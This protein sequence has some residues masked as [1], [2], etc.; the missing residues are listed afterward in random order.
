MNVVIEGK[1]LE[2]LLDDLRREHR[3]LDTQIS[4]MQTGIAFDPLLIRRLKRRKLQL[5]DQIAR[6]SDQL[7]PDIIA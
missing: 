2:V 4:E 3:A 5:K 1:A 6:I 7:Y